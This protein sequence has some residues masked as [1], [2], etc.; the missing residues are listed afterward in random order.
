VN[1]RLALGMTRKGNLSVTEYIS[2]MKAL[3]NE[4]IAAGR[5]LD[6]ELIEYIIAGVDEKYTPFVFAI[7]A[8]T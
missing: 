8:R 7:C 2:K 3:G 1:T 4:M 6:D 5:L